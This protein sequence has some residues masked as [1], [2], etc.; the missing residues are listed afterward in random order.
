VRLST[1]ITVEG[2][3]L[4]RTFLA[5]ATKDAAVYEMSDEQAQKK[6]LSSDLVLSKRMITFA[7]DGEP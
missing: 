4:I 7:P 2:R 3:S 1:V 5:G 6:K